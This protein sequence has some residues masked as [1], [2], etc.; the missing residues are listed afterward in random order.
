[1]VQI[2]VLVDPRDGDLRYVGQTRNALSRRLRDHLADKRPCHR[3]N[4]I[5]LLVRIGL[6]PIIR[7]V[8][9][10][11]QD[12]AND[13]ERYWISWFKSENCRL[14]NSTDGG[15]GVYNPTN[16]VRAKISDSNKRRKATDV[17][18]AKMREAHLGKKHNEDTKLKISN[19]TKGHVKDSVWR[20]KLSKANKGKRHS[21][22]AETKD[23]IAN[24]RRGTQRVEGRWVKNKSPG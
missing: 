22:T 24:S 16:D 5:Q 7:I 14:V 11:T 17:T 20:E 6:R 23:K 21:H 10:V 13:A 9:H 15:D 8:Q 19:S 18:R 2:Y 4:W 12:E 3:T 1:M